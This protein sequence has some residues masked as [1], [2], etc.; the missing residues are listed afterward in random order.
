LSFS[1]T[2]I[3]SMNSFHLLNSINLR[4]IL[5]KL[6]IKITLNKEISGYNQLLF[7]I[8]LLYSQMILVEELILN[9]T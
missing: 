8:K 9:L 4:Q 2:K 3:S 6:L 5:A 1:K 7:K